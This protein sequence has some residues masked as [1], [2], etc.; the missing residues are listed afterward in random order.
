MDIIGSRVLWLPYHLMLEH[1]F[2]CGTI[3]G[4]NNVCRWVR[5]APGLFVTGDKL[6][7][8][9]IDGERASDE[10][11]SGLEHG[12]SVSVAAW[13]D[14]FNKK[15]ISALQCMLGWILKLCSRK[16]EFKCE[17]VQVRVPKAPLMLSRL[18]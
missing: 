11:W 15:V 17:A 5:N 8:S 10:A 13:A 2:S 1:F 9:D 4:A 12:V 18:A 3:N 14:G 6:R 16:G 7:N